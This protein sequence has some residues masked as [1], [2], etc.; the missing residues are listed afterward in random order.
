MLAGAA[1]PRSMSSTGQSASATRR[2]RNAPD[3][4]RLGAPLTQPALRLL[5]NFLDMAI[6]ADRDPG[7]LFGPGFAARYYDC[8]RNESKRSL[9]SF[10]PI[11]VCSRIFLIA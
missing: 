7:P 3:L 4:L 11:K 6:L 10:R 9:A 5:L 1:S 2:E 8:A